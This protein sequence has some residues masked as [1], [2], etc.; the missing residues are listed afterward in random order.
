M[1]LKFVF[2]VTFWD[3]NSLSE[4]M[5]FLPSSLILWQAT[6]HEWQKECQLLRTQMQM[7]E[8]RHLNAIIRHMSYEYQLQ[9]V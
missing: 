5:V 9:Y 3:M 4:M 7:Q 6:A 1:M 8:R 2:V